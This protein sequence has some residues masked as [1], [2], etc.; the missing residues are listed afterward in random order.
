M[1]PQTRHERCQ[2][3]RFDDTCNTNCN[4]NAQA[5]RDRPGFVFV[6]AGLITEE[7]LA[8]AIVKQQQLQYFTDLDKVLIEMG[9]MTD[10]QRVKVLAG[11][12]DIPYIDLAHTTV[13]PEIA[14]MMPQQVC[15]RYKAI[16]VALDGIKLTVVMVNPLN[17]YASDEMQRITG[18]SIVPAFATEDDIMMAISNAFREQVQA[19]HVLNE[20]VQELDDATVSLEETHENP[21]DDMSVEELRELSGVAPVVRLSNLLMAD[22]IREKASDIHIEPYRENLRVRYRVDG[23]M[24]DM[25]IVPRPVQASLTSRI[26]IMANI[27]IAEKRIPQDGRI[28]LSVDG[29]HYDLRVNSLPSLFGEKIVLRVLDRSSISVDFNKL[30]MLRD[31]M[32]MFEKMISRPYGFILVTGPT[33]SGKSTTLYSALSRLNNGLNNVLTIE[34]PVEYDLPGVTQVNVNQKAEMT[35]AAGLRAMMRQD[36]DVIMVG[37]IRDKETAVIAVEAALTG[38]LV[39][40]T[41]HTNDAPGAIARLID[42]GVEPFLIASSLLGVISQRLLRA[43]CT[44]CKQEYQPDLDSMKR[45]N[46][47]EIEIDPSQKFYRGAGCAK[48]KNTGYKGRTGVFELMPVTEDIRNMILHREPTHAIRRAAKDAGMIS[49]REDGIKKILLGQTTLDESI[50]VIYSS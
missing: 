6:K 36:P 17:V 22:A 38:H 21:D 30:G 24:R 2:N 48:C 49:M 16:P 13:V 11:S 26:K 47:T 45:L 4:T 40:S 25:M 5:P 20:V 15:R 35:F 10:Q 7:Q 39:L 43:I 27:D 14:R 50:R 3:C 1:S 41:L 8:L 33:G 12:W 18:K 32:T 34:D 44:E 31:T 46:M 42:M 28:S 19:S 29:K 9:M 37:E 23:I